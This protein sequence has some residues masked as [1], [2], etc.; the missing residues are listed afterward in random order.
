MRTFRWASL[1][2]LAVLASLMTMVL[3]VAAA[4]AKPL[5]AAEPAQAARP[6]HPPYRLRFRHS[7]KCLDNW[8]ATFIQ[9]RPQQQYTCV[10]G[11]RYQFWHLDH[12]FEIGNLDYYR[13][14]ND[15]SDMCLNI[16]NG[17][18]ANG[19]VVVQFACGEYNNEYFTFIGRPDGH[20]LVQNYGSGRCL[21]VEGGSAFDHDR[22]IQ[23][24]CD[25]FPVSGVAYHNEWVRL[26]HS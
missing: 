9:S 19:A 2:L 6:P 1:A 14:R 21:N 7:A 18:V 11:A 25:A 23:Y 12:V 10:F 16:A 15:Q 24:D 13:I 20:Y 3:G 5:S 8:G 4:Q 26:E 22:I 17:S